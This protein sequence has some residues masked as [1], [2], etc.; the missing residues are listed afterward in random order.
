MATKTQKIAIIKKL[1]PPVVLTGKETMA[2]LDAIIAE[3]NGVEPAETTEEGI[4]PSVPNKDAQ[5]AVHF[6]LTD[7]SKRSFSQSEHG[8]DFAVIANEFHETN[9]Q[10]IHKRIDE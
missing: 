9:K 10:R 6:S 1:N 5:T 3:R 2:E 8:D 7:G 4:T